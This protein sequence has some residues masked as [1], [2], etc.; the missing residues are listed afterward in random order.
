MIHSSD[1][2]TDRRTDGRTIRAIEFYAVA[3]KNDDDDSLMPAT[4]AQETC[5]T[6]RYKSSCTSNLHVC[7]SIW[8][9][10]FFWYTFL[11]R[12][13]I[14]A[15][16]LSGTWHEPCNVIG[17]RVVLVQENCDEL[18]S[19]FSCKFHGA[20]FSLWYNFVE[21]VS[22]ALWWL[23]N[24]HE[25][26][27]SGVRWTLMTV[28]RQGVLITAPVLTAWPSTPVCVHLASEVWRVMSTW[29]SVSRRR[30]TTTQHAMT[31]SIPLCEWVKHCVRNPE[32][33]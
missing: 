10:F 6:N 5:T 11:A 2:Q 3:R 29:T 24:M 26:Q 31:P 7:R 15:Q 20:S 1:R 28:P 32:K 25:R 18:A 13:S 33:N 8:Y 4:H 23:M 21:R 30:A 19:N 9:K 17:R 12:S 27:V 22:P 14:P 16:K